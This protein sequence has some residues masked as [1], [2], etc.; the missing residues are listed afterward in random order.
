MN[1]CAIKAADWWALQIRINSSDSTIKELIPFQ[2]Q[3][4]NHLSYIISRDGTLT[5]STCNKRSSLLD[6]IAEKVM[7]PVEIPTGYEMKILI[8][9]IFVYNKNGELVADF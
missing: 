9:K 3:L 7:L 6:Y 2:V 8:D 5:I 4:I 1:I